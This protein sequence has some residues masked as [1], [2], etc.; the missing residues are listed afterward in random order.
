VHARLP[1][2]LSTLELPDPE[3][4]AAQLDGELF[5]LGDGWHVLDSPETVGSRALAVQLIAFPGAIAERLTAAWI[6]GA[7]DAP[8]TR[9]HLAM[10]IA[11]RTRV[12][13]SVRFQLR[14]VVIRSEETLSAAGLK[15]TTPMRTIHD[16]ARCASVAPP[17]RSV[18]LRN[19]MRIGRLT[20]DECIRT[21]LRRSKLPGKRAAIERIRAEVQ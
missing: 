10:N 19:L 9:H 16:L 11:A 2:L 12:S 20:P 4:R 17:L 7:I 13:P 3:L 8:P 5:P 6:L 1:S 18:A 21:I 14:E 15:V